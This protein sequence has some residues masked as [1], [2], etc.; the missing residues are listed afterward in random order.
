MRKTALR[1]MRFK[2]CS[3]GTSTTRALRLPQLFFQRENRAGP[4]LLRRVGGAAHEEADLF[5]RALVLVPQDDDTAI[6]LGQTLEGALEALAF[7]AGDGVLTGR[8]AVGDEVN[9]PARA[10]RDLAIQL[11]LLRFLVLPG[12]VGHVVEKDA[13]DPGLELGAGAAFKALDRLLHVQVRFLHNVR[14]AYFRLQIRPQFGPRQKVEVAPAALQQLPE[15][16][17]FSAL[18]V[19]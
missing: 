16:L 6:I 9:W 8:G 4:E 11:A 3:G 7:F 13:L 2:D 12:A 15:G 14:C 5:E 18:S 17:A 10:E 1:L 19:T